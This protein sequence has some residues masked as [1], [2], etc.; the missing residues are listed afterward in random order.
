MAQ[1]LYAAGESGMGYVMF[2]IAYR[3]ASRS[4]HLSGNAVDFVQLA[5]GKTASE[6]DNIFPHAGRG[7][8]DY[9][10]NPKYYWCLFE[11]IR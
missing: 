7:S 10:E 1:H 9:L 5:Q 8:K 6:I 4:R 2:E 11:E 3:D